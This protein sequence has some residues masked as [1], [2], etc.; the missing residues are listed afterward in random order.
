M[1]PYV[2]SGLAE[3]DKITRRGKISRGP[4]DGKGTESSDPSRGYK[5]NGEDTKGNQRDRKEHKVQ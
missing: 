4:G 2:R 5:E 1:L 3:K